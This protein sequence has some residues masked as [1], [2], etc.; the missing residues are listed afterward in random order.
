[1]RELEFPIYP[2]AVG[3]RLRWA[4]VA[5]GAAIALAVTVTLTVLGVGLKLFPGSTSA[6]APATG[7]GLAA[8]WWSLGAGVAAYLAGGWFASRLSDCGRRADGVLYGLVTWAA[9]TLA[10]VYLPAFALGAGTSISAAG[11]FAFATLALEAAAA[12]L[13]GLAGA[14]LYLPVPIAEYRREHRE[15]VKS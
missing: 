13:G 12:A 1:M 2:L 3:P 6:A 14:R 15:A 7:I 8:S 10:S 11:T 4:A 5:A 9:G